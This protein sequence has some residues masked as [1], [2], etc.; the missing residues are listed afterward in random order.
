MPTRKESA[1]ATKDG[2]IDSIVPL[3]LRALQMC[4]HETFMDCPYYEQLMFAGDT[5]LEVV[6]V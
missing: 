4:A 2:R 5:R 1:I 3:A 6:D